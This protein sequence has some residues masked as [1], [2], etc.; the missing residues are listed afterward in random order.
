MTPAAEST[1]VTSI[2]SRA[3]RWSRNSAPPS[4][5]ATTSTGVSTAP[6]SRSSGTTSSA[7]TARGPGRTARRPPSSPLLRPAR[8]SRRSA[9][10]SEGLE[11]IKG[12]D[13]GWVAPG[14]SRDQKVD[15]ILVALEPGDV[16]EGLQLADGY[17]IYQEGA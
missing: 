11:A 7:T 12:G 8:A 6:R 1:A 17:H 3:A 4:S 9:E 5:T 2:G 14:Q 13:L 15:D 16:S 10:I